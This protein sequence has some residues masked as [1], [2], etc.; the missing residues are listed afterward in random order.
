MKKIAIIILVCIFASVFATTVY[1]EPTE[2]WPWGPE[3]EYWEGVII[4]E[5]D[6]VLG[7]ENY[8]SEEVFDFYG[9]PAVKIRFPGGGDAEEE[10]LEKYGWCMYRVY[11]DSSITTREAVEALYGNEAFVDVRPEILAPIDT[12]RGDVNG[13]DTVD[14]FDYLAIKSHHFGVSELSE[15]E[16]DRADINNDGVV[17]IFD[18]MEV[19]TICFK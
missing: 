17:D 18:Y 1:A 16:L 13:D 19:K 11:L 15:E 14:M 9:I 12:L 2:A 4:I 3:I 7:V 10:W 6:Y 5:T 8:P